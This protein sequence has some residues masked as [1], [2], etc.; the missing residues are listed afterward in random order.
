MDDA[1]RKAE[2][3]IEA[4]SY[5]RMFR[6][7]LTVIKLGGSAM[8]DAD[9]LKATLQ[10][11]IFMETVGLRPVLVHGGG[12]AIDDAMAR[13]GLQ[14]RKI[15]GR[16][17]TDA[18]TLEI[19]VNVLLREINEGVVRSIR[20]LGGRAVG[21]HSGSLQCLFGERLR[22]PGA[23]GEAIDLGF[24]GRV[25]H[26]E[27]P[28]IES[29][30]AGGVVPVI[31]SVAVDIATTGETPGPPDRAEGWLNV[32]ADTAAAAVAAHLHAEKLVFLTDTPGILLDRGRPD[33]LLPSLNAARCREL[34]ERRVIDA[35]MIP[36]VEACLDSLRA[37]VRKTH[38]IDGRL[39][40]S[41]L[42]EIYTDRGVGTEITLN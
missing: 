42:L 3:L 19:V 40:H 33:S 4:R 5:I 6:D 21:L 2:A 8:A 25:A 7:K 28:L 17:Y 16:R 32:N 31:P 34:I 9:A 37:G 18:A 41:L 10:D 36:K 20:Q 15:Q 22:L 38:M 29:F 26:V 11:V 12:K 13:S 14:P 24:V 39:R 27:G 30:C 1:I 35:G 23:G